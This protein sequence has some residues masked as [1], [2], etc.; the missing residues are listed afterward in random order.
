MVDGEYL[1]VSPWSVKNGMYIQGY[2]SNFLVKY[3]HY[4]PVP[5]KYDELNKKEREQ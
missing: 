5:T 2:D 3:L 4:D 1:E